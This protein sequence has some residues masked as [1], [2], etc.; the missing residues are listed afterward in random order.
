MAV[1]VK[2]YSLGLHLAHATVDHLLVQ[3]EVRDTVTQQTADSVLF[4][5]DMYQMA[6]TGQLLGTGHTRWAGTDNR[7]PLATL[8]TGDLWLDQS[9]FHPFS[10]MESSMVLMVTGS[11]S[12]LRVH[13]SWQGAGQMR[14]VNSGKLLVECRV[15]MADCQAP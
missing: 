5:V 8:V 10:T 3:L 9:I 7:H 14:P 12:R 1:G 4:L 11:S 2:T 15:S 6:C 13:A